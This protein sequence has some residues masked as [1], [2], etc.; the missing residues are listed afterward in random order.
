[1]SDEPVAAILHVVRCPCRPFTNLYVN[2]VE[3][4]ICPNC[5]NAIQEPPCPINQTNSPAAT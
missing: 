3:G 5:G 4:A 1:M 2:V